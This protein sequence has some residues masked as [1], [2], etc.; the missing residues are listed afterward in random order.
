MTSTHR[1][2]AEV[3]SALRSIISGFPSLSRACET[4]QRFVELERLED[5]ETLNTRTRGRLQ[6]LAALHPLLANY[7]T[8]GI[9][10]GTMLHDIP[11][12]VHGIKAADQRILDGQGFAGFNG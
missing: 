8:L 7:V 12:L 4:T 1:L 11:L 6:L 10:A 9:P 5:A 3:L 2:D